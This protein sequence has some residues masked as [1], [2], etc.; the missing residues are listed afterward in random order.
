ML[1]TP[2]P[3]AYAFDARAARRDTTDT[4]LISAADAAAFSLIT[5]F[6]AAFAA[7]PC[8]SRQSSV[9]ATR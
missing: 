7:T 5:P 8:F 1:L 3:A 4:L 9:S 6:R 2:L